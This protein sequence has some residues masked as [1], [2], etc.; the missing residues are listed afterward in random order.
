M[1]ADDAISSV[2]ERAKQFKKPEKPRKP[3]LGYQY[4]GET[5]TNLGDILTPGAPQESGGSCGPAF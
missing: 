2:L 1:N 3:A 5:Y 4:I